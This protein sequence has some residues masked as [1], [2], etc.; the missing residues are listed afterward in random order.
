MTSK[1]IKMHHKGRLKAVLAAIYFGQNV[2][3]HSVLVLLSNDSY[4]IIY[5]GSIILTYLIYGL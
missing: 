5:K 3:T 1:P 2:S 4:V